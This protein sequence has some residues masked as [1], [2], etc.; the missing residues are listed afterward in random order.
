MAPQRLD[1]KNTST[2]PSA[3]LALAPKGTQIFKKVARVFSVSVASQGFAALSVLSI[4]VMDPASSDSY[5]IG[6]QIGTATFAGYSIGVVY[7]IAIGRPSFSHWGLSMLGALAST[8]VL[9][10]IIGGALSAVGQSQSVDGYIIGVFAVGSA[11]LGVAGVQA[12]RLACAGQPLRLAMMTIPSNVALTLGSLFVWALNL[13]SNWVPAALWAAVAV[14]Q[15]ALGVRSYSAAR[16]AQVTR[17]A[18]E[19]GAHASGLV[20][21]SIVASVAP[22]LYLAAVSQLA[23]GVVSTLFVVWRVL[24][25]V[26]NTGVSSLLLVAYSWS[27]RMKGAIPISSVLGCIGALPIL[28]SILGHLA[29][30]SPLLTYGVGLAG[31][32]CYVVASALCMREANAQTMSRTIL[33]KSI[34]DV[35]ASTAAICLLFIH[36]SVMGFFAAYLVSQGVTLGVIATKFGSRWGLTAGV[37]AFAAAG[38]LLV[39]G[40]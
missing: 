34:I 23:A 14:G 33:V 24:N 1:S 36:P 17:L 22:T 6:L 10:G 21:G 26:V 37:F 28:V 12:A 32:L 13:D 2:A 35:F 15:A 3:R 40:W 25:S 38:Y 18:P 9:A 29:G 7:N 39:A 16:T 8:V 5:A 27:T 31:V 19:T 20:L 4:I 30:W 11:A